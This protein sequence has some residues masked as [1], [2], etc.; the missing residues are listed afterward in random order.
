MSK[1]LKGLWDYTNFSRNTTFK[2]IS[3]AFSIMFWFYVMG[4]INP[5][6]TTTLENL[7]VELLNVAELSESGLVIIGQTD[8]AVQVKIGGRRNDVYKISAE[9]IKISA[10]TRGFQSGIN[11]IPLEITVPA[12]VE[13]KDF[14]PKQ[15]K[16][17]LDR[18][19]QKPKPV[20]IIRV[21]RPIDGFMAEPPRVEP[22]EILVLGPETFVNNVDKVFGEIDV[23]GLTEP[24]SKNIPLKAVDSDGKEVGGVTLG[25]AYAGVYLPVYRFGSLPVV[26]DLTGEVDENYRIVSVEAVPESVYIQGGTEAIEGI[27]TLDTEPF[28]VTELTETTELELPLV[29]PENLLTPYLEGPVK[30]LIKIEPVKTK[31]LVLSSDVLIVENLDLGLT[32][33]LADIDKDITVKIKDVES[34]LEAVN[35][36]GILLTVDLEGLGKGVHEASIEYKGNRFIGL[37]ILPK[38]IRI[39]ILEENSDDETATP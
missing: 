2:I 8:Y 31:E 23:S 24:V 35:P 3:I 30:V 19:V 21:N 11:S 22:Q 4:D 1:F 32:T 27:K 17:E 6:V 39:E 7:S 20:Q 10:D 12:G 13:L 34:V 29:V 28:D 5:E 18:V 9:D 33:N 16:V 15:I 25:Q 37:E 38:T 14:A 26:V 36:N